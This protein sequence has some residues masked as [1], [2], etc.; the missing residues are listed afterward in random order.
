MPQDVSPGLAAPNRQGSIS[1]LE[2]IQD[3]ILGHFQPSLRDWFISPIFPQD[4]VLGYSQ[5]SLRDLMWRR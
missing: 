4:Y 2:V 3:F 5:P 1:E